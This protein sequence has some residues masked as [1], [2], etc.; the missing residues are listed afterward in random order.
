MSTVDTC[1]TPEE[2]WG[3]VHH[4]LG[5]ILLVV[6]MVVNERQNGWESVIADSKAKLVSHLEKIARRMDESGNSKDG[7]KIGEICRIVKESDLANLANID[8]VRA[9]TKSL[10]YGTAAQALRVKVQELFGK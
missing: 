5:N 6:R 2:G 1:T 10:E 3:L 7:E 8:I 9:K 4:F